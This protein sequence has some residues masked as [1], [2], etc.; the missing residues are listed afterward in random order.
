VTDNERNQGL[1][2]TTAKAYEQ[3]DSCTKLCTNYS[4][5]K[6]AAVVAEEIL[7]SRGVDI[8]MCLNGLEVDG[9]VVSCPYGAVRPA[10]MQALVDEVSA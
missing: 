2:A 8:S 5:G 7:S 6:T 10:V 9:V 3:F 1:D 4:L